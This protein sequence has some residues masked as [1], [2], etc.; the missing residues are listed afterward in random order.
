MGLYLGNKIITPSIVSQG[1]GG[2]ETVTATNNTGSAIS[3]GDKV[4]INKEGTDYKLVDFYKKYYNNFNVVGSPVIDRGIGYAYGFS[5]SNIIA[6]KNILDTN[7]PWEIGLKFATSSNVTTRQKLNGSTIGVD[8]SFPTI[9]FGRDGVAKFRMDVSSNGTSWSIGDVIGTYT[10]LA[11]TWYWVRFGWD[12]SEYYLDYSLDGETFTRDITIV[13]STAA[14]QSSNYMGIGNDLFSTTS[15]YLKPF[16]GSM[17]LSGCYIKSNNVVLWTPA[18]NI[19]SDNIT[20]D[21]LTGIANDNFTAASTS[22]NVDYPGSYIGTVLTDYIVSQ[23]K[24][25]TNITVYKDKSFECIFKVKDTGRSGEG[26]LVD[27]WGVGKAETAFYIRNGSSRLWGVAN[28][29]AQQYGYTYTI[30]NINQWYYIKTFYDPSTHTITYYWSYDKNSWTTIWSYTF[31]SSTWFYG[32]SSNNMELIVYIG[33]RKDNSAIYGGLTDLSE[34]YFKVDDQIV[35]N[36]TTFAPGSTGDVEIGEIIEPTLGTKTITVNGT[37]NA[38]SDNLDGF[39]SVT[40]DVPSAPTKKYNLLDRVKDDSNNEI[41]TVSGFFTDANNVEY[42]VVCLDAQYR[43]EDVTWCSNTSTVVTDLPIYSGSQW[44]PWEAKETAT[45]NTQKIL[46]FCTA[47][48]YTSGACSHCRSKSFT[49]DGT[50]YY[51]QVPNMLEINDIVRNHTAINIADTTA[52]SYSSYDFSEG[53]LAWSSS[54]YSNTRAWIAS[55]FGAM[56]NTEKNGPYFV[57]PVLE[58]PNQ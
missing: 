3:E 13:N 48:G 8:Y 29:G 46:D 28:P 49:I 30:P 26:A 4:W 55:K 17:D 58:I 1:S 34:C 38:S 14:Y 12:G 22:L 10:L 23:T 19:I 18:E 40:V 50:T 36:G 42:A 53:R 39:S 54:Q 47:N 37:Y 11:N 5:V 9:E 25:S 24:A 16:L 45:F 7:Y 27:A 21:T 2:G 52:S 56:Q 6:V 15:S 51:G 43:T 20:G 57:V 33:F 41:G 35:W 32:E 31:S 44:G